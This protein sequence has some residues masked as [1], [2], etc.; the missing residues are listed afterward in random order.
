MA[1][2]PPYVF[3]MRQIVASENLPKCHILPCNLDDMAVLEV[4]TKIAK[5]IVEL[6]TFKL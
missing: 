1:Q 4:G 6:D 3:Y 2:L 5:L